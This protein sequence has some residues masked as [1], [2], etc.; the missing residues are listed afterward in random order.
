MIHRH[1]STPSVQ[2]ITI[3]SLSES[4]SSDEGCRTLS[5]VL[6]DECKVLQDIKKILDKRVSIDEQYA[7]NLQDLTASANKIL[8]PINTHPIAP[9]KKKKT[10]HV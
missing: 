3:K 6:T 8:W 1:L 7:K 10:I 5:N 4:F 2:A 9:V